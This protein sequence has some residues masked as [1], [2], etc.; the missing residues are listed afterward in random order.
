MIFTSRMMY[1]VDN[2]YLPRRVIR[3]QLPTVL[4][5]TDHPNENYTAP[6]LDTQDHLIKNRQ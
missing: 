5:I 6:S 2:L 3:T 1:V 4:I